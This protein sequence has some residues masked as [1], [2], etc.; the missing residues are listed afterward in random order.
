MIEINNLSGFE[1]NED[2][3]KKILRNVLSE[4]SLIEKKV[5]V[6][7]VKKE[8]IRKINFKYRKKD[9][10]TD[11]LS[12]S[13]DEK[14]FPENNLLGEIVICPSKVRE[15]AEKFNL[16]FQKELS[17]VLIHGILHLAGYDHENSPF[18]AEEMRKKEEKYLKLYGK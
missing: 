9:K 11:V 17:R 13:C 3:F 12:F 18:K 6:A 2:I 7:L 15:N 14:N 16:S 10:A 8:E 5:S 1:I 4:E